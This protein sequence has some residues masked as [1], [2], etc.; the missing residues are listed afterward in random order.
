MKV[1]KTIFYTTGIIPWL[2]IIPLIIFYFHT[3]SILGYFPSYNSPDPKELS[4]YNDYSFIWTFIN[5]WLVSLVIWLLSTI[6]YLII[7]RKKRNWHLIL[8]SSTGNILAI[9]LVFSKLFWWY[10]D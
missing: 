8:F 3:S 5:I 2:L 7:S 6:V 1:W 4:I 9:G 10:I